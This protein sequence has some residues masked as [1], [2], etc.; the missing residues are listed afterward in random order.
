VG[1]E[2]DPE[3]ERRS[4]AVDLVESMA[5]L[6]ERVLSRRDA[7]RLYREG[8][9]R[10]VATRLNLRGKALEERI[11][12]LL[13]SDPTTSGSAALDSHAFRRALAAINEGYRRLEDHVHPRRGR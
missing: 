7:I 6:Y 5:Q 12:V 3:P 2:E 9:E 11:R 10:A 1:P 4:E 8:F 13:P